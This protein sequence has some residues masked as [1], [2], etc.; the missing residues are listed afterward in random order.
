MCS[1]SPYPCQAPNREPTI[2]LGPSEVSSTAHLK[3]CSRP[4]EI[5]LASGRPL[6]REGLV[7]HSMTWAACDVQAEDPETKLREVPDMTMGYIGRSGAGAKIIV[8]PWTCFR[9]DISWHRLSS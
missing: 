9:D 2:P 7:V 6:S 1:G 8:M 5:V 4:N 3:F